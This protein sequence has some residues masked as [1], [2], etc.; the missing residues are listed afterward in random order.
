[1]PGADFEFLD[2]LL[3]RV[4]TQEGVDAAVLII[5]HTKIQRAEANGG[6]VKVGVAEGA[7][8]VRGGGSHNS[9]LDARYA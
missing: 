3:D 8:G 4:G 7:Q 9:L 2:R 5:A 6:K 1:M